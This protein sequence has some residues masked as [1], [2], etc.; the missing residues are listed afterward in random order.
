MSVLCEQCTVVD[1]NGIAASS[2]IGDD[3]CHFCAYGIRHVSVKSLCYA[4]LWLFA[5]TVSNFKCVFAST[6]SNFKCVCVCVESIL[7][8]DLC[9]YVQCSLWSRKKM[10]TAL[11]EM[12]CFSSYAPIQQLTQT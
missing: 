10:H 11:L 2:G 9:I 7:K 12:F 6:F 5:S 3:I 8:N 1:H 4:P